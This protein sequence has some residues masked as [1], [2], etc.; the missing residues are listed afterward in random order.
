M[1]MIPVLIGGALAIVGGM[2]VQWATHYFASER[3]REKILLEKAEKLTHAIYAHRKF[4]DRVPGIFLLGIKDSYLPDPMDEVRALRELYFPSLKPEMDAL[5]D[6]VG[7]IMEHLLHESLK[8]SEN[9]D[10]WK[11]TYDD[12]QLATVMKAYHGAS[13]SLILAITRKIPAAVRR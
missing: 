3:E 2:V 10:E 8:R 4:L 11:K 7:V 13:D 9:K 5:D 12:S 1:D 6:A